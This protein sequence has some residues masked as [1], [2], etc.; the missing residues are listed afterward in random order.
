MET[1]S[2]WNLALKYG[3]VLAF[4]NIIINLAFFFISPDAMTQ[5]YSASGLIQLLLVAVS[6][7]FIFYKAAIERRDSELGGH[8]TFG[9]SFGFMMTTALPAAFIISIY[10]FVFVKFINPGFMDKVME[11]QAQQMYEQGQSEETIQRAME[12][13]KMMSSPTV[14][15]IFGIVGS[16]F[17]SLIFALIASIFTRK[18]QPTDDIQ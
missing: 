17:Q 8:M 18:T 5:K 16:L 6:A 7:I 13:T 14:L 11:Q 15:T 3:L 9:N 12:M 1:K 4:S 2:P 10:T